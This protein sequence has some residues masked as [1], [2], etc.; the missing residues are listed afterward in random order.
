M[1]LLAN[2]R[3]G[4]KGLPGPNALAYFASIIDK[5]KKFYNID[6]WSLIKVIKFLLIL[7]P[8]TNVINLFYV[9]FN[10]ATK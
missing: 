8:W 1:S 6:Y 7:G 5:E 9:V 2:N 10:G 4:S 3:L